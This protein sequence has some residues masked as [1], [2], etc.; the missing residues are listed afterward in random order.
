MANNNIAVDIHPDGSYTITDKRSGQVF[1]GLGIYENCGDIGNEYVFRQPDGDTALTTRGLPASIRLVENEPYRVT[2]EIVHEWEVPASA[3]ELFTE[4]KR[5]MVPFRKR[6]AGRSSSTIPLRIVTRL[7]LEQSG[8]GVL[9]STSFN[10]QAKDHR[11]RVLFPTGLDANTH[12][13]DSI[14]EAAERDTVPAEEW[15]NPSNAQHQQAFVSVSGHSAASGKNAGLTIANKGLNEYEVL[16]DGSNTIAITL[17]RSV[18]ELGDWGVFPTPEAQCTGEQTVEYAI[19]PHSNSAIES[20]AF[21][22]AYQYQTPWFHSQTAYQ[23]G[24]LPTTWQPLKW[25][26]STLALSAFKMSLEH[27]DVILRL[28]NLDRKAT[29]L[30]IEPGFAIQK[31]F[32]SDILERRHQELNLSGGQLSTEVGKAQIVTY[33]LSPQCK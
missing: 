2:Y 12:L 4:E 15:V 9:V 13:A 21:A 30:A 7:S 14:F 16:Q 19:L 20:G 1:A 31:L 28:Y 32:A 5:K 26:G 23:E 24:S 22:R 25:E 6:Q 29:T 8:E 33:A 18:S 17:L 10:N 27:E 11:L 3:D